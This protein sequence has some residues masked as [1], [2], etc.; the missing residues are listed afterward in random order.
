[1]DIKYLYASPAVKVTEVQFSGVLCG[2]FDATVVP[3][4]PVWTDEL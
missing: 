1:M 4:N 2:S 3:E